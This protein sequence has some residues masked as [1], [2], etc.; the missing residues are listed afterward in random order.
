MAAAGVGMGSN[1]T[2]N[3]GTPTAHGGG[4]NAVTIDAFKQQTSRFA[5]TLSS[6][7]Q[8]GMA[9]VQAVAGPG[10]PV[11]VIGAPPPH[12]HQQQTPT[13]SSSPSHFASNIYGG[14]HG[15][16]HGSSFVASLAAKTQQQQQQYG[17]A[18]PMSN[19][20]NTTTPKSLTP[21]NNGNATPSASNNAAS[22]AAALSQEEKT[23][24]IKEHVG[25]LFPGERIIMF[26]ANLLHVGDTSGTS[27]SAAQSQDGSMWCCIMTYYRIVLFSTRKATTKIEPP[28]GWD[29]VSSQSVCGVSFQLH[30]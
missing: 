18:S 17:G 22:S 30:L 4:Q 21:T 12:H 23:R 6:M 7:A 13:S 26:L 28:P 1:T 20:I 15:G 11:N 5:S 16:A 24:L 27:F 8:R 19:G 25:D 9:Q 3:N 14:G 29:P 2:T 10:Q